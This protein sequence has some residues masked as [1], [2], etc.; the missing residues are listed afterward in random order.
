MTGK[1][2][3]LM[4]CA[5]SAL[6]PGMAHAQVGTPPNAALL[7]TAEESF[8][9]DAASARD[10]TEQPASPAPE[11]QAP[12]TQAEE[13]TQ[14]DAVLV[15]ERMI[16]VTG[17]RFASAL[18]EPQSVTII[19]AEERNLSGVGDVRQLIQVQ[20]GIN[21][22]QEFGLNVR[23]VGR[24]T[25]Q[26]LLGQENTV[27]QYVD[28]FIN[29]VP[30]NIAESTL[31][32]GNIQFVRGPSGTTYGRNS[33]AGAV[34]L[35]S[36][37][38]TDQFVG[39]AVAG[40][41]RGGYYNLG[42]NLSG[43]I[44]DN[45][46]FRAGVEKFDTPS[47]Q[48]NLG[49]D[50]DAGYATSNFYAEFQLEWRVDG[51][52]IRNRATTF[53]YD[54]QPRY[55]SRDFY[56]TGSPATA[57]TPATAVFGDLAPNPQFNFG[58]PVPSGPNEINVDF[59]GY[60]RLREN[61]QNITN[62][63]LDLGFATLFYVGGY[64]QYVATGSADLDQTSRSSYDPFAPG[65]GGVP[66]APIFAPGTIVPTDYRS[67]YLNDNNFWS[68]E[69][70]LESNSS[71]NIEWVL[72]YYHFEQ[73]FDEQYWENIPGATAALATPQ[74]STVDPAPGAPNPRLATFEQRNIFDI[75][76]DAVFGNITWDLTPNIR[77]DG[78]LR[79]T[80][81]EK[82][83][84]TD[85]RYVFYY[86]P[87][88]AA[89]VSPAVSGANTFRQ[90]EGVSGRASLA[91]RSNSGDQVY[92]S[93][94]RGY[95]ASA[96]TLGQGLPPNNVAEPQT[97]DVYELGGNLSLGNVRFDGAVFY[98]NLFDQQIPV[99]SRGTI[100][101]PTGPVAGPIFTTFT[102]AELSRIYG[103]EAQITW[104][105]TP[106][107]NIVASY[108]YLNATF[109]RF[110]GAIDLTEPATINGSPNQLAGVPQDLSGNRIPRTPENKATIYGYHGISLGNAG[111]LYP[112]GSLS[113]QSDYYTSP[114]EVERFRV[115]G[116]V[117]AG[118]TLTYRTD[119]E[120]LDVTASVS[121][122]FRNRYVDD[123]VIQSFGGVTARTGQN[124]GAD[125]FWSVTARYR[126]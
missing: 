112:G 69:L 87:V 60:D 33:L 89:D 8:G 25:A 41:G 120:N 115:P 91:W 21:F 38:P 75:R 13:D 74:V 2:L 32:G 96:F 102:N 19:S 85:F 73:S 9:M 57:T 37:S 22:S 103:T 114:F 58:G 35:V 80:W 52:H 5:A 18:D 76:S 6:L 82:E 47:Y 119:R 48:R 100:S 94:Q 92:L 122:L 90:D 46:G 34:N 45:L 70:R 117:I 20:P 86:P 62:A 118:L 66:V 49:P 56:I 77:F 124:Y 42:V 107:T 26:T 29:L 101:T 4:S 55:P 54:N 126:F 84:L 98:Q 11:T 51:F 14:S 43:P 17:N 109:R 63:D 110:D 99:A 23:G 3:L 7:A 78:G 105:P 64:Q 53:S 95:Q 116:R 24:Q 97:L 31:F 40:F 88:F 36:R 67:N 123:Y 93:Y 81:D 15:E 111:M 83:A 104:R 65:V 16:V 30:S 113:Y 61:F 28:G 108:T 121:N 106:M 1:Y 68:Q 72:G 125:R 12:E 10:G 59:T 71:G 44:T 27:T 79:H 39:Q 50:K